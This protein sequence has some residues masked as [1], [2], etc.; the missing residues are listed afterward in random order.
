M[1]VQKWKSGKRAS[2]SLPSGKRQS[3]SVGNRRSKAR[4]RNAATSNNIYNDDVF[5]E[6]VFPDMEIGGSMSPDWSP[7]T[8]MFGEATLSPLPGSPPVSPTSYLY[9]IKSLL[10][11][12]VAGETN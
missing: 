7:S 8:M 2:G 6:A 12:D 3:S 1:K 11:E 9:D 5:E 10:A 4:R